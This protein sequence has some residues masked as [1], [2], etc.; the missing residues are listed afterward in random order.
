MVEKPKK[1]GLLFGSSFDVNC[2]V[3]KNDQ[4]DVI[5]EGQPSRKGLICMVWWCKK[6]GSMCFQ[7]GLGLT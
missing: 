2:F 5:K 7:G 4:K 6:G 3:V 1:R